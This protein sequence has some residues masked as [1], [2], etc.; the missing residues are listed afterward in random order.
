[1][2][3]APRSA[4][5]PF[6]ARGTSGARSI[7]VGPP[8]AKCDTQGDFTT[9]RFDLSEIKRCR[10]FLNSSFVSDNRTLLLSF[11][12]IERAKI[13]FANRLGSGLL[14]NNISKLRMIRELYDGEQVSW[15]FAIANVK[16]Y[17]VHQFETRDITSARDERLRVNEMLDEWKYKI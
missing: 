12:W 14:R 2:G 7:S 6:S 15:K 4:R 9:L 13:V 17:I 5:V 10:T 8:N 11:A 16:Y 3:P 1:M